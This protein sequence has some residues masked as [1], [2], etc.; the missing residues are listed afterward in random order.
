MCEVSVIVPSY[1]VENFI[2]KCLI[3]IAQQTFDNFEVIIIDDSFLDNTRN[4]I[5]KFIKNDTRFKLIELEEK[6]SVSFKRNLGIDNAKG[7]YILF[8]DSDDYVKKEL[9]LDV[10]SYTIDNNLEICQFDLTKI[11]EK[12]NCLKANAGNFS[13]KIVNYNKDNFLYN[14][15]NYMVSKREI[16]YCH[17]K[18][19]KSSIVKNKHKFQED[20]FIGEDLLFN[21]LILQDINKIGYLDKS[22]YF[23]VQHNKSITKNKEGLELVLPSYF[24]I[25]ANTTEM[26][27]KVNNEYVGI[28]YFLFIKF[29]MLAMHFM[30][31][32]T[33]ND[34]VVI[35]DIFDKFFNE[36]KF[37]E[38]VSLLDFENSIDI[39]FKIVE[40]DRYTKDDYLSFIESIILRNGAIAKR[41]EKF[42][43]Y[44]ANKKL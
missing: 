3:S 17:T 8:V 16:N 37:F 4:L 5:K 9:L 44:S 40:N 42:D 12:G 19:Y 25:Y 11:D 29:M 35:E 1:N 10:Y 21:Y 32:K 39:Y 13:R 41:Q 27:E 28:N 34:Y 22:Y 7:N 31:V 30:K 2:E 20:V 23:Y 33:E 14:I 24:K 43:N 18:L 26:I 6:K 36:N 38:K 15:I